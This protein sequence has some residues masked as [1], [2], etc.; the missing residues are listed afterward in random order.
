MLFSQTLLEKRFIQWTYRT[1]TLPFEVGISL[2]DV[3]CRSHRE[4]EVYGSISIGKD[5][6][7]LDGFVVPTGDCDWDRPLGVSDLFIVFTARK[8]FLCWIGFSPGFKEIE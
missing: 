6:G 5:A 7:G 2:E 3:I 1:V 4:K 8:N